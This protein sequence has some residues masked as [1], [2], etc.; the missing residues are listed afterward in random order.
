MVAFVSCSLRVRYFSTVQGDYLLSKSGDNN[1]SKSGILLYKSHN[2]IG[3]HSAPL[4]NF[5]SGWMDQSSDMTVFSIVEII[6][7]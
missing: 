6:K 7:M 3:C 2:S 5:I 1:S 4:T